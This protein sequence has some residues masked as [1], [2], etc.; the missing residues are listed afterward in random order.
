MKHERK[1]RITE[2]VVRWFFNHARLNGY[3]QVAYPISHFTLSKMIGETFSIAMQPIANL[4]TEKVAKVLQRLN[5]PF[6]Q[7]ALD[8]YSDVAGFLYA[9]RGG[10][11]IFIEET[12]TEERQKFSL[13]HELGHFINDY[14]RPVYLKYENTR[15][16]PL[17]SQEES[18]KVVSAR[19]T[20]S[21]IFGAEGYLRQRLSRDEG[22]LLTWHKEKFREI[23]A[24]GFAAELLM[25]MEEC[26]R[27]EHE[28]QG[29]SQEELTL[30]L[31]RRFGVSRS[32]A[33]IRVEE[34]RLGMVEEGLW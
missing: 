21:D 23:K 6:E 13:A 8:R 20:K 1:H 33:A 12:D 10:G 28:N 15:T 9:S 24:N 34:L 17:F 11:I 5:L 25:P 4:T 14:Y 30:A 18:D 7:S 22:N 27:I 26:R 29:A 16:I 31:I 2:D 3:N 19:C 32:A